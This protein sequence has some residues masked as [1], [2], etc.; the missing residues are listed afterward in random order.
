MV[1]GVTMAQVYSNIYGIVN[2]FYVYIHLESGVGK[3]DCDS[4]TP[5]M[6]A[7]AFGI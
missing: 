2:W 5:W 1:G 7:L 4:D 3:S 6:A